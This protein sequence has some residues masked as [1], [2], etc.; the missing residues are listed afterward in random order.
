MGRI[1]E[2]RRDINKGAAGIAGLLMD[3][4][5]L[6]MLDSY[7]DGYVKTIQQARDEQTPLHVLEDQLLGVDHASIG[8][9]LINGMGL[10]KVFAD[11]AR[12][13]TMSAKQLAEMESTDSKTLIIAAVAAASIGDFFC[14]GSQSAS[15]AIVETVCV[16]LLGFETLQ[17]QALFDGVRQD[18]EAKADMFSV[19]VSD[20]PSTSHLLGRA[21]EQALHTPQL[22][23]RSTDSENDAIQQQNQRMQETALVAGKPY[24]SRRADGKPTTGNICA[25]DWSKR[26]SML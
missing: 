13:H 22:L 23:Q 3:L 9:K 4:G 25:G 20:L 24:L 17:L 2:V 8:D 16:D 21:N 14:R 12:C 6:L 10:P 19:D 5:Q 15:L 26:C 7:P 18:I 1:A 11:V